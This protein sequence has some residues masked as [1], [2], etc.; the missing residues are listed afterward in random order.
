MAKE[1]KKRLVAV[2]TRDVKFHDHM[3]KGTKVYDKE[4]KVLI[5]A[6]VAK[7]DE[8]EAIASLTEA[9]EAEEAAIQAAHAEFKVEEQARQEA[10]MKAAKAAM[11]KHRDERL[12]QSSPSLKAAL[13]AE[14]AKETAAPAAG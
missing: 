10:E 3:R 2:L 1:K 7:L 12:A 11:R 9:I 13:A 8:T 5:G 4:A 6:G 14:T